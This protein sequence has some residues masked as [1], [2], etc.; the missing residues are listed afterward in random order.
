MAAR[1]GNLDQVTFLLQVGADVNIRDKDGVS[2]RHVLSP[3]A[4]WVQ[5]QQFSHSIAQ[6]N[7]PFGTCS[8]ST[9]RNRFQIH[10]SLIHVCRN[11]NSV[12]QQ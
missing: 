11:D 4:E 5:I 7:T 1:H 2:M 9:N 10:L 3:G 6:I 8:N 12:K